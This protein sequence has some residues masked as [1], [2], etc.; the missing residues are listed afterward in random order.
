MRAICVLALVLPGA[1]HA[2]GATTSKPTSRLAGDTSAAPA[3]AP[4]T[5]RAG[6]NV[7]LGDILD[8]VARGDEAAVADL[9]L[10][11]VKLSRQ[12]SLLYARRLIL[13]SQLQ[14]LMSQKFGAQ[15]TRP[16]MLRGQ[17]EF[18]PR[19][20]PAALKWD[21]DRPS[22]QSVAVGSLEV[23]IGRPADRS[24]NWIVMARTATGWKLDRSG[25]A[26]A[27][28]AMHL[29]DAP[30]RNAVV[31][32]VIDAVKS[33]KLSSAEA[34]ADALTLHA[35]A[36][37]PDAQKADRSTP[38]GAIVALFDAMENGDAATV[39]DSF[40]YMR[41]SDNGATRRQF[42]E[43][44]V[45]DRKL[46]KALV[47]KFGPEQGERLEADCGLRAMWLDI[48]R[49]VPWVVDG[50][51]A[52]AAIDQDRYGHR[53]DV[54]MRMIRGGGV[55]RIQYPPA[56]L[57]EWRRPKTE[58]EKKLDGWIAERARRENDVLAHLDQYPTPG[59]VL[60]VLQYAR[61]EERQS[62]GEKRTKEVDQQVRDARKQL[63]TRPAATTEEA[64][65]QQMGMTILE[66]SAALVHQDAAAAAKF[67]VAD[68]DD[69]DYAL[70]RET[71][72][73]AIHQLVEAADKQ[74]DSGAERL[75]HELQLLD[76][77]DDLY[78]L[79]M[80]EWKVQ[81]ERAVG[82]KPEGV[83][84]EAFWLPTLRKV[85]GAWKI[86]VTKETGG[87]PKQAARRAHEET[88]KIQ[89]IIQQVKE[90]KFKKLDQLK[91][92]LVGAGIKGANKP[93]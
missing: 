52:R 42:A 3:R 50:D 44:A 70:A 47:A 4:A 11:P 76:V 28:V 17:L 36:T 49:Q 80:I 22:P 90:L 87:D 82:A 18:I 55:W 19:L 35:P 29:E 8:A 7:A 12:Q 72:A 63:A 64:F 45:A 75:I 91:G 89:Q 2:H 30:W 83:G 34:V 6:L 24:G 67:Y 39:A 93:M 43:R 15:A 86:D 14:W 78:G 69:G 31:R 27:L 41:E 58:D 84:E 53:Y 68:G 62:D 71:R 79:A 25:G 48:Y 74:I 26:G 65:D 54:G 37:R 61:V 85:G 21:A 33:G 88:V 60:E 1:G 9:M 5:D 59:S 13:G 57:V 10:M 92:A 20:D 23:A 51:V 40:Q 16:V 56:D 81:G 77:A 32:R 46:A 73:L 66:L 38:E